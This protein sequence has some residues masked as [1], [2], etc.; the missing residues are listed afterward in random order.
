M[1]FNFA[2]FWEHT[3]QRI[4]YDENLESLEN[5]SN[6]SINDLKQYPPQQCAL[7]TTPTFKPIS[8]QIERRDVLRR[9][10]SPAKL[11]LSKTKQRDYMESLSKW[12]NKKYKK[13]TTK[14]QY[15]DDEEWETE[16]SFDSGEW[17]TDSDYD[18]IDTIPS[19]TTESRR[20]GLT[21]LEDDI[22]FPEPTKFYLDIDNSRQKQQRKVGSPPLKQTTPL[23]HQHS[24]A[25]AV[26]KL[27]K[28]PKYLSVP[29]LDKR[30]SSEGKRLRRK[31]IDPKAKIKWKGDEAKRLK[32]CISALMQMRFHDQLAYSGT[33]QI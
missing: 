22:K 20:K 18:T 33:V 30:I 31:P 23:L 26:T 17:E 10:S 6:L 24:S 13:W 21:K 15:E 9:L 27:L 32:V 25:G 2:Q 11:R 7:P 19:I 5:F 16:S 8:R 14:R 12:V 3:N 1:A 29:K 28:G 4:R